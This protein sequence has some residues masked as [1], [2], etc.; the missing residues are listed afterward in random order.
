MLYFPLYFNLYPYLYFFKFN[1]IRRT[2]NKNTMNCPQCKDHLENSEDYAFSRLSA[3]IAGEAD[4]YA[5]K[6]IT[7]QSNKGFNE[8]KPNKLDLYMMY[9]RIEYTRLNNLKKSK[10]I[11]EYFNVISPKYSGNPDLCLKCTVPDSYDFNKDVRFCFHA[12]SDDEGC[13]NC[14]K[15]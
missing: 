3:E 4:S 15:N 10:Y 6:M 8:D 14:S 5:I 13:S 12:Q 1:N 7:L 9:Y 11:D 2:N